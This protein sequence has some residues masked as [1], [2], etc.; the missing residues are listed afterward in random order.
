M[1]TPDQEYISSP[2]ELSIA[3][4]HQ[5]RPRAV[6][7]MDDDVV[8]WLEFEMG[9]VECADGVHC[10]DDGAVAFLS[11]ALPSQ[12]LTD[13]AQGSQD[14]GAVEALPF[15]VFT[16]AHGMSVLQAGGPVT[17][18]EVWRSE[19]ERMPRSS[20]AKASR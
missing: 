18:M 13:L 14:A 20:M 16:E 12:F 7:L 2:I 9:Y 8:V 4:R 10:R 15:T 19:W 3:A 5:S 6:G 11:A 1:R 17:F